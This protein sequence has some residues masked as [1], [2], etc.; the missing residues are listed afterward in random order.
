MKYNSLLLIL[1]T[2]LLI[3]FSGCDKEPKTADVT[4]GISH[5]VNGATVNL[6][7]I[8]YTNA[9]SNQFSVTRLQYYI[10]GVKLAMEGGTV[11]E[12]A[13][14]YYID[15]ED[16]NTHEFTIANVPV[17]TITGIDLLLGV[18]DSRN[19]D[20]GL[21]ATTVNNNMI[22]PAAIGGGAYHHMKFEGNFLDSTSS[23]VGFALHLGKN[24]NQPN[25]TVTGLNVAVSGDGENHV[26]LN[27]DINEWF[28]NPNTWDL[29][30]LHQGLMMNDSAQT[31]MFE[32][33]VDVISR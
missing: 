28:Q 7:S 13:G 18:E 29:D 11:H 24:G 16:A 6:N 15:I 26:P 17:G 5:D 21:E 14:V 10:S 2:S 1:A 23:T 4:I 20:G 25:N 22:W 30:G 9:D 8:E 3:V 12:D 32:N 31:L 27:Y 19:I 33:G